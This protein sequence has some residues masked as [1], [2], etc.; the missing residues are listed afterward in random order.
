MRELCHEHIHVVHTSFSITLVEFSETS[1]EYEFV[2]VGSEWEACFGYL[3]VGRYF[4]QTVSL[5]RIVG[6]CVD[7]ILYM[8]AEF[9]VFNEIWIGEQCCPRAFRIVLFQL[10]NIRFGCLRVAH[11]RIEQ[12]QMIEHVGHVLVFRIAVGDTS[13]SLFAQWQIVEFVLEYYTGVVE[14]VHYYK[15]AGLYLFLCER[16]LFEIVLSFVWIVLRA[17]GYQFERIGYGF[18]LCYGVELFFGHLQ[19]FAKGHD[20]L[21]HALPVVHVFSLSPFLLEFGFTL[22]HCHLVVEVPHRI[23]VCLSGSLLIVVVY[24]VHSASVLRYYLLRFLLSQLVLFFLFL[25][26]QSFYHAVDGFVTLFLVH[27]CQC[28]ERV[29]QMDSICVRH[30]FVENL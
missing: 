10:L 12:E 6:C 1:D 13:E 8:F 21:V 30:K 26:L 16:Y 7:G 20:G 17:V 14:A 18:G 9:G 24:V 19:L 5:E 2:A 28:L 3:Q 11:S 15:I 29:L 22:I 23:F 25:F 4:L 27:F